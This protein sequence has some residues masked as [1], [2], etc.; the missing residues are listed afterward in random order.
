M[1][2]PNRR[3]IP[4]CAG[5]PFAI[6]PP[7]AVQSGLSPRVRGNPA[8]WD[9]CVR[10]KL[11]VYPRVCGGTLYKM[12]RVQTR[13][14]PGLSPRVRG[15]HSLAR[16]LPGWFLGLSPRVRG[17]PNRPGFERGRDSYGVYPRVCGGTPQRITMTTGV[18]NCWGLSPRVRG[19]L[20]MSTLDQASYQGLSPRVRG[21][22]QTHVGAARAAARVYPRVCGGTGLRLV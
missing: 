15:N 3:S 5:E 10:V 22:R 18:T 12:T 1:L 17:N 9:S 7:S 2:E 13:T 4:A 11:R 19:N 14:G 21:N 20:A 8:R 6:T 16:V